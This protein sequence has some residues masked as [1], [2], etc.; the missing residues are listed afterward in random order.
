MAGLSTLDSAMLGWDPSMKIYDP[1]TRA[2]CC[3][4]TPG[5]DM[6]L[7][8]K[9]RFSTC[10]AI[11]FPDENGQTQRFVTLHAISVVGSKMLFGTA[12]LVWE[13]AKEKDLRNG[14][15]IVSLPLIPISPIDE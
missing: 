13:V 11:N 1:K 6:K 4:H 10:F 7:F 14:K 15:Q 8:G 3:S 5:L 9:D 12:T 2:V